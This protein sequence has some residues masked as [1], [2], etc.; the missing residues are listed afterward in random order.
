MVSVSTSRQWVKVPARA[1]ASSV[2]ILES[3]SGDK[4]SF[5][6]ETYNVVIGDE[7]WQYD[8]IDEW[9]ANYQRG[10]FARLYIARDGASLTLSIDQLFGP[11]SVA[12]GGTVSTT[13]AD[14]L[15][16]LAPIREA[17]EE[18]SNQ[19]SRPVEPEPEPESVQV[20]I[21][22]GR[23]ADWRDIKDELVDKHGITVETY[24]TGARAGHTIRDVLDGML[25]RSTV[26]FLVMTGEDETANGGTRARQN[27]VH[28][29]GLFQGTLGFP[30][31]IA[32]VEEGVEVFSNIAGVQ[33]IRYPKGHPKSAVSDILA[34]IRREFPSSRS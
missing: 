2:E 26:A 16:M 4:P 20:F 24:E 32:V 31:A 21:G 5:L 11:P 29:V 30:R 17:L 23:S 13:T 33:Q 6:S 12:V 15:S 1:I 14:L 9:Y 19:I 18:P 27:V 10:S 8:S 34:T 7:D 28:E 22:H 25:E 3:L